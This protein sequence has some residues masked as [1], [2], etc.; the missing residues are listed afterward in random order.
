[1]RTAPAKQGEPDA[2]DAGHRLKPGMEFVVAPEVIDPNELITAGT[3]AG[4]ELKLS[5]GHPWW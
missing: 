2:Y 4:P 1:M 3:K 5:R